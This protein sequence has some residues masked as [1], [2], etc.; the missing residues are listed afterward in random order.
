MWGYEESLN[1]WLVCADLCLRHRLHAF[2]HPLDEHKLDC[3]YIIHTVRLFKAQ[4]DD[5]WQLTEHIWTTNWPHARGRKQHCRSTT[6]TSDL[7]VHHRQTWGEPV[8]SLH[9]HLGRML[10]TYK[11]M[12]LSLQSKQC[13]YHCFLTCKHSSHASHEFQ[14]CYPILTDLIN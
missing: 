2:P 14:F 6:V 9:H 3:W 4:C 12:G 7:T 11:N 13:P 5:Q 1:W 10:H 8:V